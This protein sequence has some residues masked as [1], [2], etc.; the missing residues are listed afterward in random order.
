[1]LQP[2]GAPLY[3]MEMSYQKVLDFNP[4]YSLL[5]QQPQDIL[6]GLSS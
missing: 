2:F 1:M 6:E 5:R 3:T 4:V